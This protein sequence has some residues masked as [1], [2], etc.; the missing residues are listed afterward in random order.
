LAQ[1][2]PPAAA[3]EGQVASSRRCSRARV[4]W[5]GWLLRRAAGG[6]WPASSLASLSRICGCARGLFSCAARNLPAWH[7]PQLAEPPCPAPCPRPPPF[8]PLSTHTL[9]AFPQVYQAE[10]RVRLKLGWR[11]ALLYRV[12]PGAIWAWALAAAGLVLAG[13]GA[14]GLAAS[15]LLIKFAL[16]RSRGAPAGGGGGLARGADQRC[17]AGGL[18]WRWRCAAPA[19][20]AGQRRGAAAGADAGRR[21]VGG[22]LERCR[23]PHGGSIGHAPTCW[24]ALQGRRSP[25]Q[26]V[27]PLPPPLPPLQVSKG[28][29][30][31]PRRSAWA[32]WRLSLRSA[33]ARGPRRGGQGT[34]P[35][36]CVSGGAG[37]GGGVPGQDGCP[38]CRRCQAL[39]RWLHRLP[40]VP[41]LPG[42]C[43]GQLRG[44]GPRG[45]WRWG[46]RC[47]AAC[48]QALMR[49]ALLQAP[50]AAEATRPRYQRAAS[51]AGRRPVAGPRR[52]TPC[53]A[54][55]ATRTGR[56]SAQRP[57]TMAAGRVAGS[58]WRLPP[59]CPA[60]ARGRAPGPGAAAS[61]GLRPFCP[62]GGAFTFSPDG[63]RWARLA[64]G[65]R[66]GGDYWA[67]GS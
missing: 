11:Q 64:A 22:Q 65:G 10:L 53:G 61:A 45:R 24:S 17:C 1:R 7:K 54:G 63:R 33:R 42:T 34:T 5:S 14:A 32:G 60:V 44:R 18:C 29:W 43:S 25:G 4:P 37:G 40:T 55:C 66:A 15:L 9:A 16:P 39:L 12:R 28:S 23:G 67:W 49:A 52:A 35:Q 47:P 13:S 6:A 57:G 27:A 19:G 56:R 30:S 62:S 51:G 58:G 8:Q 2:W 3:A 41:S 38:L 50:G 36:V 46:G 20:N 31:R 59:C 21:A 48:S 26:Q